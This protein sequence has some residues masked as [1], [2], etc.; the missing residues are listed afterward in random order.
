MEITLWWFLFFTKY[1]KVFDCLIIEYEC[2]FLK[3]FSWE[4]KMKKSYSM[5]II[6]FDVFISTFNN[7]SPTKFKIKILKDSYIDIN[8]SLLNSNEVYYFIIGDPLS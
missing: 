3:W 6:K 5:I 2:W 4:V 7:D 8:F 1:Q